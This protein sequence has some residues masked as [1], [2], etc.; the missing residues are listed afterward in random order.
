M[1]IFVSGHKCVLN[2]HPHSFRR[3]G[4]VDGLTSPAVIVE[5]TGNTGFVEQPSAEE[6]LQEIVHNQHLS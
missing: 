5:P 2:T 1:V 4:I 6:N 3:S